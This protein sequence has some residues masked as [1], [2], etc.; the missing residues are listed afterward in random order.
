[1]SKVATSLSQF[2]MWQRTAWVKDKKTKKKVKG[3][4]GP[5]HQG[6]CPPRIAGQ[7]FYR[8]KDVAS[9]EENNIWTNALRIATEAV[10]NPKKFAIRTE[11]VKDLH[12]TSDLARKRNTPELGKGAQFINKMNQVFPVIEGRKVDNNECLEIWNDPTL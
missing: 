5:L 11:Q 3:P 2:S 1:M 7:P 12:Y 4:N 8:K 10:L 9:L 6:L